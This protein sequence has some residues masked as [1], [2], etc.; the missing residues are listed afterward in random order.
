[1]VEKEDAKPDEPLCIERMPTPQE[2]LLARANGEVLEIPNCYEDIRPIQIT[3]E[4]SRGIFAKVTVPL[5]E[6]KTIPQLLAELKETPS[7]VIEGFEKEPD[8]EYIERQDILEKS[9]GIF[10]KTSDFQTGIPLTQLL[11]C[12]LYTSDAADD[13]LCVDLGG[14]RIIK[15]KKKK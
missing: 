3:N 7:H 15:K 10:A 4:K 8:Q 2:L 5:E 11:I 13:L 12:L 9:K 1:M 6:E 14:R